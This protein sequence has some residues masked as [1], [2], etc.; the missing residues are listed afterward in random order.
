VGE[1]DTVKECFAAD[2]CIKSRWREPRLD[3]QVTLV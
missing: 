2:V 3:G 1:I